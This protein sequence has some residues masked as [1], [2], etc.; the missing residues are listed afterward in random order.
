MPPGPNNLRSNRPAGHLLLLGC[1]NRKRAVKGKLPA[2]QLYDGVNFRV[3]RGFLN[4][5]GWPPGLCIKILSAKYGLID[6]TDLIE[7]YD[8]RLEATTA[9]KFN[10]KVL[11]TLARFGKPRSAFINLGKDYLPAIAGIDRLYDEDRIISRWPR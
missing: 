11:K 6:A 1:S 4:E 3:L 2:L 10:R 7:I 8:E 5:R 9:Q